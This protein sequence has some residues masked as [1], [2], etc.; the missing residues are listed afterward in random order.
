MHS[1][2]RGGH[3]SSLLAFAAPEQC[4]A[5]RS[6]SGVDATGDCFVRYAD[7]CNVYVRSLEKGAQ[8][9][10][11]TATS[12]RTAHRPLA[13]TG[14][15]CPGSHDFNCS[16]RPIR[17]RMPGVA[18]GDWS[19]KLAAPVPMRGTGGA[20]TMSN[21]N[22]CDEAIWGRNHAT[23]ARFLLIGRKEGR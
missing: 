7:A 1:A 9:R 8:V 18:G 23:Q 20:S 2:T 12:D 22:P 15:A 4:V 17:A 11:I 14:S 6:G 3:S 21:A 16:N 5:G 19:D 13:S 10:R